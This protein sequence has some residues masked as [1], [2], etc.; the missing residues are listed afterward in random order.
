MSNS[1]YEPKYSAGYEYRIG[2]TSYF[3]EKIEGGMYFERCSNFAGYTC[4]RCDVFDANRGVETS[5]SLGIG[6]VPHSESRSA[7]EPA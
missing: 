4:S 3:I 5:V 1:N 2:N 6:L 7:H